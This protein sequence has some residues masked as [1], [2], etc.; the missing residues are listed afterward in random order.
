[1]PRERRRMNEWK[2]VT[3]TIQSKGLVQRRPRQEKKQIEVA[4][5]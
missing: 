1:M 2:L 4:G 5:R 3:Y